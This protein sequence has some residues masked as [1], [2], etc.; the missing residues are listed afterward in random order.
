LDEDR[1]SPF[2]LVGALA[3]AAG[4]PRGPSPDPLLRAL[5]DAIPEPV[6]LKDLE[7]R[8][9]FANPAVLRVVGLPLEAVLGRTDAEIHGDE[10]VAAALRANDL[11]V[12]STGVAEV[13]EEEINGPAGPRFFLSTKAPYRDATGRVVGLIGSAREIT[14]RKAAEVAVQR[15]LGLRLE[16]ERRLA[17]QE[18]HQHAM[19]AAAL[20][21]Y[22]VV[23]AE[24]KVQE[25]NDAAC[26]MSGYTRQELLG[27]RVADL[28]AVEDAAATA[29]HVRRI[30]EQGSDRFESR[31]RRKDGTVIDV[32]VSVRYLPEAQ[33]IVTFLRD[34][35]ERRRAEAERGE[36]EAFFRALLE[37]S[38]D[39]ILLAD[40]EGRY[41][42]WSP[43]ATE[44]LGWTAAEAVGRTA[45]ELA[46]PED[47]PGLEAALA[48]L[49][50]AP[51]ETLRMRVPFPH[52]DGRV[53]ILEGAARNL[54]SDPAVRG[55]VINARDVTGAHELEA[56]L[57]Q[58][59]K[60]ESIGRLAGGVA[61]DFNN[62]LTVIL[63]CTGALR[64]DAAEGRAAS[65]EEVEEIHAAGLRAR[66][67]TRQLLAFARKQVIAPERL[68]LNQVVSASEKLLRR[69]LGEDVELV[70]GL[71][72]DLWP[73]RCDPGQVEQV[74]LNLVVNAR[75][76][77]PG[78][79]RL[80]LSTLNHRVDAE[81]SA[82]S[83]GQ[84]VGEWV[85]L[86]V[87][88]TGT[89][90]TPEVQA[91]LFEPFFTTKPAGQGTGLGLA[92]VYG[93]VQQ[94]GGHL[95]VESAPG[96]GTVLRVC[97]PR[98]AGQGAAPRSAV[99]PAIGAGGGETLLVVEDDAQVRAVTVRVLREAGYRV[100][101]ADG[102]PTA[103]DLSRAEPA[104]IDL[105][106]TDVVMPLLGGREVADA[107]RRQRPGLEVLFVSGYAQ[108]AIAHR[109]VLEPGVNFLAKPYSS[110]ELL[111]RVRT[112]L[113]R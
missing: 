16:S 66:D 42:F 80:S 110:E 101:A 54:L 8:W 7:G 55:I 22:W 33:V 69:V 82:Q 83:P 1:S 70:V 86:E 53:R 65:T 113:G 20:D 25:A 29:A 24:G 34:V 35:T 18:R 48:G 73:I 77:M 78:G 32:E 93:I 102:G 56:Q 95:H 37:K 79:G 100:L 47:R 87:R 112:L 44:V 26:A 84:L 5:T 90:M 52:K 63:S 28:E 105:V 14:E 50:A 38:S 19:L 67:L 61:H 30:L 85:Q 74:L 2:D 109:G 103:L 46:P 49:L 23:S 75:D 13:I 15:E 104:R 31:H 107:L 11:R 88:D 58:A 21:A 57:R 62:L 51:G 71:A 108:E 12:T 97:L 59:Q 9:L 96:Q 92:T 43:S 6:F 64:A 94:S 40:A 17:A 45:F 3:W 81:R 60:L 99:D 106:I 68:D 111:A 76:A 89:G 10:R 27:M 41:R 39:M 98:H 36:R 91:H 72:P 4:G